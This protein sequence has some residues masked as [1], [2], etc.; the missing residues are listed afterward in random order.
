M[1]NSAELAVVYNIEDL[2]ADN[3]SGDAADNEW[4]WDDDSDAADKQTN[5]KS[6]AKAVKVKKPGKVHSVKVK[7]KNAKKVTTKSRYTLS[8]KR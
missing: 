2:N 3:S 1:K 8:W 4:S 6:S 5:N 7:K